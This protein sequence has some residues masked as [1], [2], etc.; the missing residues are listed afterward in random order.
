MTLYNILIN[1]MGCLAILMQVLDEFV[2]PRD[3]NSTE[4][5]NPLIEI[6]DLF[7]FLIFW[8]GFGLML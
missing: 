8:L 5:Q 7:M 4:T 2:I 1:S 3:P 6:A